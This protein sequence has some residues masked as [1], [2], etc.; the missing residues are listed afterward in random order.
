MCGHSTI[1]MWLLHSHQVIALWSSTNNVHLPK[2]NCLESLE[3]T[4]LYCTA[5]NRRSHLV[6]ISCDST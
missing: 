6:W 4:A 2:A 1:T 3:Y 5:I